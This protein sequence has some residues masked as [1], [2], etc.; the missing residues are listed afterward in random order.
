MPLDNQHA[1]GGAKPPPASLL[2]GWMLLF[3][4]F[5][6][7]AGFVIVSP[8]LE[9]LPLVGSTIEVLRESGIDVGAWYYDDVDEVSEAERFM[10]RT[11]G[12]GN[13]RRD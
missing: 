5:L 13:S 3:L 8:R 12:G 2:R 4:A 9:K 1:G 7:I 11:L 10:R 6:L